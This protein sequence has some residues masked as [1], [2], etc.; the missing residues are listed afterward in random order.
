MRAR[1]ALTATATAPV[2]VS[3]PGGGPLATLSV[4]E[5]EVA[6]LAAAGLSS[7]QVAE[8][9]VLSTRTVDTHLGNAYRKLGVSSRVALARL[10]GPPVA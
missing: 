1:A 3:R 5:Q 7:R 2:S 9:L 4:R 10:L 8:R 6:E